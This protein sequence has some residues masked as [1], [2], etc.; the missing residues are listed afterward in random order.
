[1]PSRGNKPP[2]LQ[3]EKGLEP[4]PQE[5]FPSMSPAKCQEEHR[6]GWAQSCSAIYKLCDLGQMT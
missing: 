2:N 3:K 5:G 4:F 1:M 6:L